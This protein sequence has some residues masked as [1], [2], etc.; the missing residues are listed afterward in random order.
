MTNSVP[1]R[2][3]ALIEAIQKQCGIPNSSYIKGIGDDCAVRKSNGKS[4]LI[5]AD[6]M[7]ENVHFRLDLM[8]LKEVGFKAISSS[9]SDI[10]AMGGT[11]CSLVVQLVFPKSDTV[12]SQ[13]EELYEGIGE[14]VRYFDTPVIGGDLAQGPCW[15]IAVTVFGDDNGKILYRSGAKVGDEIWVTGTPGLSALGLDLL[16]KQGR[17]KAQQIN[18]KAV[19]A[20]VKPLPRKELVNSFFQNENITSLIDISDGIGKE[21]LTIAKES[22]VAVEITLPDEIRSKLISVAS[23]VR[24]PEELFL[25]GG[26]D[27]ELLFTTSPG[28]DIQS[29]SV[30]LCKI[31]KVIESGTS[32]FITENGD[33]QRLTGGWDHL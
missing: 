4:T 30:P 28:I 8:S 29:E 11:G 3:Y 22:S 26:E 7:V 2:E 33:A 1:S 6:T 24:S 32:V 16:L 5:S 23:D 19:H 17:E 25:N 9:V 21:S 12:N 20:H 10:Y 27:Y 18:P 14:A 15:M 31:G 13:I